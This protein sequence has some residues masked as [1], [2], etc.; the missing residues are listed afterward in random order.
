MDGEPV[1]F[2]AYRRIQH[3]AT[4]NLKMEHRLVVLPDYQGL[5]IRSRLSEWMGQRL[6]EEGFRHQRPRDRRARFSSP[7][8]A[9]TGCGTWRLP[10]RHEGPNPGSV[11]SGP[12]L[13]VPLTRVAPSRR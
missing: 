13:R 10:V 2:L 8:A 1:A 9:G 12:S 3:P 6:Y 7:C 5:G 11:G 4:R